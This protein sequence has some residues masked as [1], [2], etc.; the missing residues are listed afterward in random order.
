MSM[1]IRSMTKEELGELL[2]ERGEPSFRA[3][4]LF[5]WLHDKEASSYDEMLNLPRKLR[6]YLAE[7]YPILPPAIA[8]RLVS[9]RDGTVKFLF[10]FADGALVE[11]VLMHFDYG[12]SLCISS[13]VGCRMGCAFCASGIRGL[14]RNLTAGEMLGEIYAASASEGIRIG[15]IVVMG[16]GEPMDNYEEIVRFLRL[17]KDPDGNALSGRSVTV[18][19]CGIVPRMYDFAREH[20]TANLALSLHAAD[21]EKRKQIMPVARA[22]T[23]DETLRA[24][25]FCGRETGRRVTVEYALI[26]GVN[27]TDADADLLGEKLRGMGV[28]CLLN[29]IP[30]NPVTEKGFRQPTSAGALRFKKRV[31]KYRINV[32]IRKEMGRDIEGACGQLRLR[33]LS[34]EDEYGQEMKAGQK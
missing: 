33:Y 8:D 1:D 22:Y 27:D 7:H 34:V 26:A 2:R 6:E 16:T 3:G 15:H 12:D 14:V 4:Q 28:P 31:E 17:L 23:V 24:L 11:S 30:V 5:G 9:Q 10:R 13:Q 19:T 25:A 20:L 21:D 32:T 29:L 18:S